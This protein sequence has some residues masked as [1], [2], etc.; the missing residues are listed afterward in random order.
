[1]VPNPSQINSATTISSTHHHHHIH[2]HL[3]PS[4]DSSNW[5]PTTEYQTPPSTYRHY[6]YPN[7]HFY[8]QSQWSTPAIKFETSYSPPSHFENVDQ[9][10]SDS[11]EEP[12]DSSYIKCPEQELNWYKPQLTPAPPKNP[13]NGMFTLIPFFLFLNDLLN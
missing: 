7:N 2:Q 8:D 6:P 1:L 11:K 3:Y 9:P 12:S 5:L 10:L 4:N 13:S